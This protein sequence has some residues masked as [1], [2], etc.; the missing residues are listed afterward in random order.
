IEGNRIVFQRLRELFPATEG[1]VLEIGP[2]EGL[3]SMMLQDTGYIIECLDVRDSEFLPTSIPIKIMDVDSPIKHTLTEGQYDA[4]IA[5]DVIEH[6]RHPW[7]FVESVFSLVRPGG[8][9]FITTPNIAG[10]LS[11]ARFLVFGEFYLFPR[12]PANLDYHNSHIMPLH[13]MT[14]E[15]MFQST[16]FTDVRILSIRRSAVLC[17]QTVR[18]ILFSLPRIIAFLFAFK[19]PRGR[20]IIVEGRK[21]ETV[22]R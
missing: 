4:V 13:W 10:V 21:P 22:A 16:G 20:H 17:F 2:G 1:R 18:S 15:N 11:R 12:P 3:L 14:I 6:L 19:G 5:I 7:Q 9:F 8:Y